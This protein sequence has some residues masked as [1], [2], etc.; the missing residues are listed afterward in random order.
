MGA[1]GFVHFLV[2]LVQQAFLV[3]IVFLDAGLGSGDG[4]QLP[5]AEGLVER[6]PAPTLNERARRSSPESGKDNRSRRGVRTDASGVP[7]IGA[8]L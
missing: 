8:C 1:F 2:E 4:E 6:P 7:P 3:A 5:G